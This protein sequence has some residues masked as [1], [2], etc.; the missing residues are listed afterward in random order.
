M[1]ILPDMAF[2]RLAQGGIW[3]I[4]EP[5]PDPFRYEY[6]PKKVYENQAVVRIAVYKLGRSRSYGSA[7]VLGQWE[8]DKDW[9]T[10]GWIEG[11]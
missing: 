6:D 8:G 4:W 10:V 11:G 3:R 7:D 1:A 5:L 9:V 2:E